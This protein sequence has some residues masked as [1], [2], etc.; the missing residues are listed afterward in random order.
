MNFIHQKNT[1]MNYPKIVTSLLIA[2]LAIT[3]PSTI[4]SAK[5]KAKLAKIADDASLNVK[6]VGESGGYVFI[7]ISVNQDSEQKSYLSIADEAGEKLHEEVVTTKE[8][9]RIIKM[10]PEE[11]KTIRV[12]YENENKL[13]AKTYTIKTTV[14]QSYLIS[15]TE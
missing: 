11:L 5:E 12:K 3:A 6:Y 13:T 9:S 14:T 10:A 4:V 7:K 8:F 15:D 1:V 2:A